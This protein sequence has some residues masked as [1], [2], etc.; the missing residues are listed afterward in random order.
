MTDGKYVEYQGRAGL[1]HRISRR[2]CDGIRRPTED[3]AHMMNVPSYRYY[4]ADT[5][6]GPAKAT[7]R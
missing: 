1:T 6:A 2:G 4:V 5:V 3:E 7:A